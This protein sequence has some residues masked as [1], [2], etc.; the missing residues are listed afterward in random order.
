MSK[1]S[2]QLERPDPVPVRVLLPFA[3][4]VLAVVAVSACDDSSTEVLPLEDKHSGGD[5]TVFDVTRDAFAR[6]IANLQGERR[7]NFFLGNSTFN[8]GW[9]IAPASVADFDGLG[10][11]FNAKSCSA[12]HFKDGRGRPPEDPGET[13]LSMLVRLSIP[14][15][16]E[17]GGPLPEPTYGD[18]LQE[19]AILGVTPEGT[20]RVS[21]AEQP[22]AFADGEPYSLRRPSYVIEKLG[23]G[24][25]HPDVELSPRTAPFIFG[26]GLLE[27]VPEAA[28]LAHADPDDRNGDGIS[29]RPNHV[30]DH[31]G[32]RTA[33][34]RF[35]WKA[36]QPSLRQQNAAAFL[37]DMGITS[38]L[39]S[40]ENCSA[41]E[42]DCQHAPIGNAPQVRDRFLDQVTFYTKT[43]GVPGRRNIDDAVVRRGRMLF[44]VAKCSACHTPSFTTGVVADFDELSNQVIH[45]FTDL[46]LHDLGPELADGRSDFEASG[47]EWRTPPLWGIGLVKTVNRHSF[48]MHDGRARGF[49][50]AILW[51]GGEGSRSRDAFVAMPK[52]D[53]DALLVF[54]GS[55]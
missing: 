26:L 29:G 16:N 24:P 27:A 12:C 55:L 53:R 34:G 33:L 22:A 30:W 40:T 43:L 28:I 45:P 19:N 48:F 11:L 54:L 14:G 39:F 44:E 3:A 18:Q 21:Y 52:S 10:P 20:S 37:G 5:T 25:L 7:D 1:Y 13:F 51:H 41:A 31:I 8:R 15:Q 42:I 50:E 6:P 38:D 2:G 23:Y 49:A 32:Q 47:S 36:N 17:H 46:L 9:I 35:G 4:F